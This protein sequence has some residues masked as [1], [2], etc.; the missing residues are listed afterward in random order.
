MLTVV[1]SGG[2]KEE[3]PIMKELATMV[4]KHDGVITG[5][6]PK[7]VVISNGNPR[8]GLLEATIMGGV[9]E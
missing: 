1:G 3:D 2:N 8:G 6:D 5:G 7:V 9:W 4:G